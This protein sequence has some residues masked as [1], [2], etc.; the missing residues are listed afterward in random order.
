MLTTPSPF[1]IFNPLHRTCSAL[2]ESGLFD[3]FEM[4]EE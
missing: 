4:R 3:R 1:S 2:F